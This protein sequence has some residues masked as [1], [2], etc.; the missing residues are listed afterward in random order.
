MISFV[1]ALIFVFVILTPF[2]YGCPTK[3]DGW[4]GKDKKE[5]KKEIVEMLRKLADMLDEQEDRNPSMVIDTPDD[6]ANPNWQNPDYNP[7]PRLPRTRNGGHP[8]KFGIDIDNSVDSVM[9]SND[10]PL[11]DDGTCGLKAAAGD[12]NK[13]NGPKIPSINKDVSINLCVPSYKF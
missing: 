6:I 13:M 5:N 4:D 9:P 7:Y 8:P 3:L 11:W 2:S 10:C 1:K 12:E